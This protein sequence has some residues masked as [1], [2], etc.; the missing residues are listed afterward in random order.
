MG[1][2]GRA[3]QEHPFDAQCA[4]KAHTPRPENLA[5]HVVAVLE[6]TLECENTQ[7]ISRKNRRER[8]AR[9]SAPNDDDVL[10][11][12]GQDSGAPLRPRRSDS[13]VAWAGVPE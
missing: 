9:D 7:A 13:P 6:L 3:H 2:V 11:L 10:F 12:H 5:S 1:R 4:G 8:A